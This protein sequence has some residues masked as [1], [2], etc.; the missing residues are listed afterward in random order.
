VPLTVGGRQVRVSCEQRGGA[1]GLGSGGWALFLT[2]GA[3]GFNVAMQSAANDVVKV[4]KGR[5]Y[6]A[7]GDAGWPASSGDGAQADMQILN[8]QLVHPTSSCATALPFRVATPAFPAVLC[9]PA[10]ATPPPPVALPAVAPAAAPAV[11]GTTCKVF[12]PGRY[13]LATKPVF[14]NRNVLRPGV[15]WF[16]N[17]GQLDITGQVW[18][19]TPGDGQAKQTSMTGPCVAPGTGGVTIVL[20]GDSSIRVTNGSKFE[21]FSPGPNISTPGLGIVTSH[22]TAPGWV[23]ADSFRTILTMQ[24][25]SNTETVIHGVVYTPN[26]RIEL[27]GGNNGLAKIVRPVVAA[28]IDIQAPNSIDPNSFGIFSDEGFGSSTNRLKARSVPAGT[29]KELCGY[30]E[31][32]LYENAPRALSVRSR[33]DNRLSAGGT[34]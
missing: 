34:C 31:F 24:N 20:T 26:A 11:T 9:S 5:T 3:P 27:V 8:G 6:N 10:I 4:V 29:E 12:R 28:A 17:V 19:G 1:G 25:G 32:L 13:T 14:A 2:T 21:L 16:D 7:K 30:A 15:Y 23:P 22:S 18:A 33:V